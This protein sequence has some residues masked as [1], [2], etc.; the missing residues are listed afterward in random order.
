MRLIV[1]SVNLRAFKARKEKK[2]EWKGKWG[3]GEWGTVAGSA[4]WDF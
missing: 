2:G 1:G 4:V 3:T